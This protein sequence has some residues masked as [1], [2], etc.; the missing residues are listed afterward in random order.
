MENELVVKSNK[1][2][3]ASYRL[4]LTEQRLILLAI[5]YARK[6]GLGLSEKNL[7]TISASDYAA[8]FGADEKSAYAQIEQAA[9]TLFSRFVVINDHHPETGKPRSSDVRWVQKTSYISGAGLV[10]LKFSDDVIPLVTRLETE[11]TSYK[12]VVVSKL[13]SAYAIRLYELLIQWGSI[14]NREIEI[15]WLKHTFQIDGEY[16]RLERLKSRV[17]DVAIKQIN[18]HSDLTVSYSQRKS[19]R[20]VTHL[21]FKFEPKALN[22]PVTS[23]S[24][25]RTKPSKISKKEIEELAR[26]GESYAEAEERIIRERAAA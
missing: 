20:T 13:S 12:L 19:G 9:K 24:T 3:E 11:F 2:I 25:T 6:T 17:I 8:Q 26:V 21:I 10:Q 4:T 7:L 18:E 16:Q 23:K 15:N 22:K 1:L 14:G 5:V